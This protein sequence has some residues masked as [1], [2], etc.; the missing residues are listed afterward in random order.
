MNEMRANLTP[1]QLHRSSAVKIRENQMCGHLRG[2]ERVQSI[3]WGLAGHMRHLVEEAQ[4]EGQSVA[5][6]DAAEAEAFADNVEW[7]IDMIVDDAY[8]LKTSLKDAGAAS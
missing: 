5:K 8:V 2:L 1:D 3:I 6:V 4:K 7:L